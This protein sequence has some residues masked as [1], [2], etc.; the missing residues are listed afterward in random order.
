[1]KNNSVFFLIPASSITNIHVSSSDAGT[2]IGTEPVNL[3]SDR[4]AFPVSI[5]YWSSAPIDPL[6][7]LHSCNRHQEI[8][9]DSKERKKQFEK[10]IYRARIRTKALSAGSHSLSPAS[11][12]VCVPSMYSQWT[13]TSLFYCYLIHFLSPSPS[14]NFISVC[15]MSSLSDT[16]SQFWPY[17]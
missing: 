1:M 6:F 4:W 5:N 8:L 17:C 10:I 16:I 9:H 3:P 13:Q 2:P 15:P 12:I 11:L 14:V 7:L